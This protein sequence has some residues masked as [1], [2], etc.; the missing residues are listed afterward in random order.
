MKSMRERAPKLYWWALA[1]GLALAALAVLGTLG[2][3]QGQSSDSESATYTV[4]FQ[5][6]F[7]ADALAADAQMPSNANLRRLAGAVHGSDVT[8]W[9]AGGTAS[10]GLKSLAEQGRTDHFTDEIEESITDGHAKQAF[11]TPDRRMPPTGLGKTRFTATRA[12]PLVTL[13]AKINPSP[14]WFVGGRDLELRPNG[15]WEREISVDLYAWDAGTEEGTEFDRENA[16][17]SPQG[18]VTSLRNAGKFSDSPIARVT[19]TLQAP[20][21]IENVEATPGNG[22]IALSW[23]GSSFAGGYRVQWKS[24]TEGFEDA[25]STGREHVVGDGATTGHT[26]TNL[27]NGAEY[28]VRV[29]AIN[30]Q[31]DGE[32]SDEVTAT[33]VDPYADDVLVSNAGQ[34]AAP[35]TQSLGSAAPQIIQGFTTGSRPALVDEVVLGGLRN[36]EPN[37]EIAVSIYSDS[38]LS[39][40]N[41]L[42]SLD[43]P[44]TLAGGDNVSF[45]IPS[46]TDAVLQANTTYYIWVERVSGSPTLMGTA[47]DE[48]DPQS[49]PGWSLADGCLF[50]S[51]SDQQSACPSSESIGVSVRGR[52]LPQL[53]IADAS[54][55]EGSNADFTVTLSAAG[56]EAVTVQYDTVDGTA[57]SDP[58]ATGGADYTAA[59]GRTLTFAPGEVSKEISIVTSDDTA[60]E[61]DET[62]TL[63][64]SSPSAN[65]EIAGS[66]TATG[67]I[68]NNDVSATSGATLSSLSL[69][70]SG[71]VDIA[72]S[73]SFS[74]LASLYTAA[75]ANDVDSLTAAAVTDDGGAAVV[76]VGADDTST[77]GQGEYDLEV[78][79]N[80]VEVRVTSGDGNN[81]SRYR[82]AVT[83]AASDDATLTSMTLADSGGTAVEMSPSP[84]SP[85]TAI[86]TASVPK[87]VDA[88]TFS[89]TKTH[90]G[91]SVLI[92]TADGNFE[93]ESATIPLNP[94]DTIIKAMVTAED[95]VTVNLYKAIVTRALIAT[96]KDTTLS[97]FTLTRSDGTEVLLSLTFDPDTRL[98][99]AA[100]PN[101]VT[102]VIATAV[103]NDS[104]ATM[105]FEDGTPTGT[106]GQVTRELAVGSNRI[107]VRITPVD[108][109]RSKFYIVMV[110]RADVGASS[111]ATLSGLTLND[112]DDAAIDVSPTPFDPSTTEYT[113][114]V[115]NSVSTVTVRADNTD[116]DATALIFSADGNHKV[117]SKSVR[118]EVGE[119]TVTVRSFAEDASTSRTY[120]LTVSRA[121]STAS[122]DSTLSALVLSASDGTALTFTP[123]FDQATTTYAASVGNA[124]DAVT[125]SAT[126]NHS[127]ATAS[128]I[129]PDGAGTADS[130]TV[131]L[132]VGENLIKA[133]VT[134]EDTSTTTIYMVTVTRA[135][136]TDATLS[137]LTL[138]D[139]GGT[140]ISL[141][142]AFDPA[143]GV[144][145]AEVENDVETLTVT[146][147]EN[148]DGAEAVFVGAA[149]TGTP[150]EATQDLAVGENL[151]KVMVT[152]E[153]GTTVKIYMV[154]VTRQSAT[155]WTATVTVDRDG[156]TVP[157]GYGYSLWGSNIDGTLSS[158]TFTIGDDEYRVQ[159]LVHLSDGLYLALNRHLPSDFVLSLG[160]AEYRGRD[161]SIPVAAGTGKY[162]WADD[163]IAWTQGQSVAVSLTMEES[164]LPTLQNAPPA[165]YFSN[166]PDGH[167][168]D[169]RF[170]FRTYF[171]DEVSIRARTLRDHSFTVTGGSIAKAKKLNRG[172]TKGWK[173]WVQ[174]DSDGD[175]T[176]TLTD[177]A[178]CEADDAICTSDGRQLHNQPAVTV[179]GPEE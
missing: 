137:S 61:D 23:D 159:L 68:V 3:A 5:G 174:P 120:T 97:S 160:G 19:F 11:E 132:D 81:V 106:P 168:G 85:D 31:G 155:V 79:E 92:V 41:L 1:M 143:T 14:D 22:E 74:S 39:S 145:E 33:V 102:S 82:I 164:S 57:T 167:D 179:P 35:L 69:T 37:T 9:S 130:A 17:T 56:A 12:F 18:V 149:G 100:V 48:E 163:Q 28:T 177:P 119:N 76:F 101:D 118:L 84:F 44:E 32:P 4:A 40:Q 161:S 107:K 127:G 129:A 25:G 24:G 83:R 95:G 63:T 111:D 153:D 13:A 154:T 70:D 115:A 125:L 80:P 94:G 46:G 53:S 126:K 131:A 104:A 147:A 71:G 77:P 166:V 103:L 8:Y 87:E 157:A 75:V 55:T 169:A 6:L 173:I 67:T 162:W 150:G 165:A 114:A 26:I 88:V 65:A 47:S 89:V 50:N 43:G 136:S 72:L 128:I 152:A 58:N 15:E 122:G 112:E 98:Y 146:V 10:D 110:T 156:S 52:Y 42:H 99:Y 90:G 144:Y 20:P 175:V 66:G 91:A 16:A 134:S 7:D 34:T 93:A 178:N 27:V 116:Q 139:S 36:V 59:T 86:Y 172:S 60:A 21:Q 108:S 133:M 109:V 54:V 105:M 38:D 148:H 73:P 62:F 124:T 171:T 138:A 49:D 158:D 176:I 96:G 170:T 117:E 113:A 30:G 140:G 51:S 121:S 135:A 78:G 64:L 45:T 2:S 123:T 151:V 142:P 29:I 141:T